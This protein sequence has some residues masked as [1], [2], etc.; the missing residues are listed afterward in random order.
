MENNQ[1]NGMQLNGIDV[2]NALGRMMGNK[3][4]LLKLLGDFYNDYE[5]FEYDLNEAIASGNSERY[6]KML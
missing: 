4:L 3:E 1:I 6:F 2:E 5:N